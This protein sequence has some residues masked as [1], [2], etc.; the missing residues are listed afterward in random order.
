MVTTTLLQIQIVYDLFNQVCNL[1]IFQ[2]KEKFKID[3]N[4]YYKIYINNQTIK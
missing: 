2:N 1:I 4:K 3:L